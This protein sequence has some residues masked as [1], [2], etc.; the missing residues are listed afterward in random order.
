MSSAVDDDFVADINVTPLVDVMLVLLII[1]MV[2]APMMAEGL[3]VELPRV[4]ESELLSVE[5]DHLV[6]TIRD[7]GSL[8]LDEVPVSPASLPAVLA[9][10]GAGRNKELFLRADKNVP[11]GVVMEVMGTLRAAGIGRLGMVTALET[12]DAGAR[13]DEARNPDIAGPQ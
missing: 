10:Q 11:Y 9:A 12:P 2:T 1:F 13:S 4:Q 7:N 8:F 6:L 5:G 3:G